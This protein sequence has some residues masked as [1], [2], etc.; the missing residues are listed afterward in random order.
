MIRSLQRRAGSQDQLCEW[1]SRGDGAHVL[2]L[3]FYTDKAE[4]REGSEGWEKY[5]KHREGRDV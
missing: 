4:G 3:L 5:R 2:E 1:E